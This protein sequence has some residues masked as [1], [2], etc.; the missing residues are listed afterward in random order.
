[1]TKDTIFKIYLIVLGCAVAVN[2]VSMIV[3]YGTDYEA[4]KL[5][6]ISLITTIALGI[7]GLAANIYFTI[8][9]T[10][11][12]GL[13]VVMWILWALIGPLFVFGPISQSV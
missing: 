13:V 5:F 1:M 4:Y 8:K 7:P 10:K 3:Y 6:F 9:I 11:T 2:A 12:R